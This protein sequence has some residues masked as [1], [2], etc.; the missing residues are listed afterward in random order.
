VRGK[1]RKI[2]VPLPIVGGEQAGSESILAA[3]R[4]A[5]KNRRVAAILFHVES[6]GGD[7]L[8]SDLIWREVER[9]RAKKPVVVLMG[10]TAASGGYY[11]SAAANHVVARRNTITG[12]IGVLS[13]RPVAENLYEKLGVNPAALQ[14]GDRAG[15]LDPSRHPTR[16]E[17]QVLETQIG[18][19]Y[20]EFKDRVSR[21]RSMEIADLEG[22]AGGRVWTGAEALELGLAD[23]V[24]GFQ[25]ALRKARQLGKIER[26]APGVLLKIPPP[27]SGRPAPG[28]PAQA[29]REMVGDIK[30]AISELL[31]YRVWAVAPYE[32]SED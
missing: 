19:I 28:D 13:I 15:L 32:I 29:A 6:P 12:S 25:E 20:D 4:L 9:I 14:R 18:F 16:D 8:A 31:V 10:N 27:R 2:P 3:L 30:L 5:E 22:I 26:D 11:V 24:G 1:S 21:G 23:E 7:A 17:M